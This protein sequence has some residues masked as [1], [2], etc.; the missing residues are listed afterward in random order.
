MTIC[1]S[2]T[3]E[4]CGGLLYDPTLQT[5]YCPIFNVAIMSNETA[6][7]VKQAIDQGNINKNLTQR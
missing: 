1:D 7:K 3:M 4:N 6:K 2:C 5:M